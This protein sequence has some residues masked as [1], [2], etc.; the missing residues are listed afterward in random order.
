MLK[1]LF[2]ILQLFSNTRRDGLLVI[3]SHFGQKRTIQK[4]LIDIFIEIQTFLRQL[5]I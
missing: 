3:R 1:D 2:L 4:A 5:K